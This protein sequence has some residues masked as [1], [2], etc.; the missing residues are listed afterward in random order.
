[1]NPNQLAQGL[2]WF[3]LGLGLAE[4]LAP[5][6]VSQTIGL[7]NH[8]DIIRA[9][10]AREFANG[11]GI[12]SGRCP[13]AWLWGRVAGDFLDLSLLGAAC[14]SRENDRGRLAG[15]IAAVAGI[16]ALDVAAS[17]AHSREDGFERRFLRGKR[18]SSATAVR[19]VITINKPAAE[20]FAFWRDLTNLPRFMTHLESVEVFD[21]KR[22]R[23]VAKGPAGRH[24]EWEAEIVEEQPGELIV[25]RSLPGS[26]VHTVGAVS[27][28]P[29]TGNRGT[30]V[31]VDLRYDP[32]AGKLGATI[33]KL[34][35][36]APETQIPTDLYR[37]KNL[38]ETGEIARTEGQPAGRP[39]STSPVYDD[40]IRT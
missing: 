11:L 27:F 12:L 36:E 15:A 17:L 20:V 2:G 6:R 14:S 5:R 32:P 35:G 23:W 9:M 13:A 7:S 38:L 30:V 37:V 4:L 1:M 16:A 8:Q 33:A 28:E 34:F 3:S 22:S 18:L 31:R 39:S 10:G 25:W 19:K 40:F 24:V 21:E 26:D 29:A